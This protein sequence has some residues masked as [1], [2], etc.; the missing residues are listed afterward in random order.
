[1]TRVSPGTRQR[2]ERLRRLLGVVVVALLGATIG[3]ALAP[4]PTV[5]V[6]PLDVQIA[7]SLQAEHPAV[8]ALPPIGEVAF[9][10]HVGPLGFRASVRSVDSQAAEVLLSSPSGL[11]DLTRTAPDAVK[12]GVLQALAWSIACT[13]VGAGSAALVVY[14]SPRRGLQAAGAV[15]VPTVV[16]CTLAASTFDAAALQQPRFTGL[17][18][19]APYLSAEG[20]SVVDRLQSYRSGV[21][22]M[23]RSVTTLYTASDELPVLDDSEVTTVLHLSDIHLNPQGF[24]LADQLVEQFSVDVVVDTGDITTWGTPAES[25]TL[26]RIG[27][28]GVPYVFVRGNH[29]SM[30]TSAAV[31]LQRGA[32]VLENES[33]TVAGLTI[34]GIGDARFTPDVGSQGLETGREAAGR[35]ASDLAA[36]V[37]ATNRAGRDVDVAVLHNPSRLDALLGEVPLIVSGHYHT[38]TVRLDESGTRVMVQGSSGGAGFTLGALN[39]LEK[40]EP[41]PLQASLLYFAS[42]GERKGELVAWDDVSVGGLGL[43]SV[44]FDRTVVPAEDADLPAAGDEDSDEDSDGDATTPTD[45]GP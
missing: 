42:S 6:G 32:I 33:V 27:R 5:Q 1:M 4:E 45:G 44:S 11:D 28:L 12:G 18:S 31:A 19:R 37:A 26:N 3:W 22:D 15:L 29:D 10:T 24:D 38:R 20:R 30:V 13:L 16:V 23:V 35:S 17:L 43:S 21:A 9:D 8:I 2:L 14:R 41:I 7:T 36:T 25:S 34:A 40:G 39:S